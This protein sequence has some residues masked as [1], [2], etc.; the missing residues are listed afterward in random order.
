MKDRYL[1]IGVIG[2]ASNTGFS[3]RDI[4]VAE[5]LGREL[6]KSNVAFIYGAEKDSNSIS[7]LVAQSTRHHGGLTI[8]V[9]YGKMEKIY[10]EADVVIATGLERGAGRETSLCFSCD[11]IITIGGGSGTMTE[12]GIAYQARIPMVAL[13]GSGG[14]S[15]KMADKYFDE[16]KRVIVRSGDTPQAVVALAIQLAIERRKISSQS[17]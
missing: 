17:T 5:D 1:Q 16:R 4:E 7:T 15:D 6:A 11:A 12:M 2:S 9:T 10:G 14:W 3:P 13:K 8:A